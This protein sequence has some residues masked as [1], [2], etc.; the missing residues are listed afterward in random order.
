MKSAKAMKILVMGLPGCGKTTLAKRLVKRLRAVHWNADKVREN[1]NE[2]LG[3]STADRIK[4]AA[5]MGWLCDQVNE[6]GHNVVADFVCPT[7]TTRE[8][9]GDRDI[10]VWMNNLDESRYQDTNRIFEPPE[11]ADLVI[12]YFDVTQ[13]EVDEETMERAV[14]EVLQFL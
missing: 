3:F 8:A 7:E 1:I 5:R 12:D 2:E 9:F 11:D 14:E 13:F 4:Q 6:A 10:L